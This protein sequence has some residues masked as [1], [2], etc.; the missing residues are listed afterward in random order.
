MTRI[1]CIIGAHGDER[2]WKLAHDF[3]FP[4]TD[5]QG[6][7]E[8][9]VAY[10]AAGTLAGVRN[11]A[12]ESAT[13][14]WLLFLDADDKLDVGF[15]AA[16]RNAIGD[17]RPDQGID[18]RLYTPAVSYTPD[19]NR[20]RPLPPKIWPRIPIENGNWLVIG[21]LISRE[22]FLAV[23]G[24]R[25]WPMY[26]DWCLWQRAMK[27]GATVVE[28]PAAVYL[29]TAHPRSRNRAPSRK[30]KLDTHERIRR[31]NYPELYEKEE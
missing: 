19:G 22:L 14:D 18:P 11:G 26:E 5:E 1:S 30:V 3:A 29:A 12:A 6:F 16:M 15:G 13:G 31:A 7:H 17:Y 25:E 21:T 2:W 10:D 28:V 24:F 27:A 23:G 9:I 8:T 4:S 20:R